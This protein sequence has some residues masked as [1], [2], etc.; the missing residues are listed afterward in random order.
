MTNPRSARGP[1]EEATRS[2]EQGTWTQ[3]GTG[4]GTGMPGG[5]AAK[6]G[7]YQVPG[8]ELASA[9]WPA[10]LAAGIGCVVVGVVLL[11]W[12]SATLAVAAILIGVALVVTGIL[13]LV[14]GFTSHE[15]TGGKRVANVVIGLI[16]ILL[17]L[18]CIR[19]YHLTIAALAVIV[20]LF[21]VI[22]GIASI[23]AGLFGSPFSGR[24]FTVL[25]GFLSLAAGLIVLFWPT[26]S[27]TVV[28]AVIGIWLIIYGLLAGYMGFRLR[29]AGQAGRRESGSGR[30][31]SA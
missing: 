18:F 17:G 6:P 25:A 21:W 8:T 31:A 26:I 9:A 23:A 7:G 27:L 13:G 22:N 14:D 16:A 10:F 5:I 30:L 24:G 4:T 15:S 3:H 19:H 12:P 29:R 1:G 11:A 28:V 2:G 20:G